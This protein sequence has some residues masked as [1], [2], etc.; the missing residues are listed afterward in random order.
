MT[1]E[2]IT[3]TAQRTFHSIEEATAFMREGEQ[4]YRLRR[5]SERFGRTPA[6]VAAEKLAKRTRR[7]QAKAS[8]KRN[9][10]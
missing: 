4:L 6:E 3:Y 5:T 7:K 1:G 2:I 9:Q 8:K 10:P